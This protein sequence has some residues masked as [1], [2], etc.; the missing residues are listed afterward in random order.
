M[1]FNNIYYINIMILF[2]KLFL[3]YRHAV[4]YRFITLFLMLLLYLIFFPFV[5]SITCFYFRKVSFKHAVQVRNNDC[6]L[7]RLDPSLWSALAFNCFFCD[8]FFW[9]ISLLTHLFHT[10]ISNQT[11]VE[12]HRPFK[13]LYFLVEYYLVY[14]MIIRILKYNVTLN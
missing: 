9:F 11:R 8:V 12:R 10:F 2:L 1:H 14:Q 5:K 7:S 13:T 6:F 4:V 3:M